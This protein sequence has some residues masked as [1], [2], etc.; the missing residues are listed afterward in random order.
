MLAAIAR[1]QLG[2]SILAAVAAGV[3]LFVWDRQPELD[4]VMSEQLEVATEQRLAALASTASLS[5]DA[6]VAAYEDGDSDATRSEQPAPA[7]YSQVPR[8]SISVVE[9]HAGGATQ[10]ELSSQHP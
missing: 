2:S 3:S 4:A 1:D 9:P 5:R 7:D 6:A 8:D 10:V